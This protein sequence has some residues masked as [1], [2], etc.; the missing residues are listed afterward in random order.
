MK[1]INL[2]GGALALTLAATLCAF[3]PGLAAQSSGNAQQPNNNS[4]PSSKTRH[5]PARLRSS[6]TGS[7]P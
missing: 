7:M 1:K 2:H 3:S 6:R 5:S 4:K